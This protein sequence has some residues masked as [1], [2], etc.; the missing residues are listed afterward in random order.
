M[1][2]PPR[3][4]SDMSTSE[5]VPRRVS[6]VTTGHGNRK[7]VDEAYDFLA[8]HVDITGGEGV[9]LTRVRRRIDWHIV[10]IMFALYFF[11]FLDK[12]L[13]NYAIIMG[14]PKDLKL[15]GNELNNVASSLWWAYLAMSPLVALIQNKVRIGKWLGINMI[16]WG[17]VISCTAAVKT[18]RQMLGVRILMGVFDAAIPPALMLLS[19]QYYRKD[20]QA[21][22]YAFWFSSV[23]WGLIC[24]GAISYGFQNVKTSTL[25]GWRKFPRWLF[26]RSGH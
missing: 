15:K 23:G 20:E 24:G 4:P 5:K 10:P 6:L 26:N 19:A 8:Q 25:E 3:Q 13:L 16:L 7:S 14:M 2:H 11:Q 18:Y 17:I 12:S 1:Q 21:M 9:D 22:R